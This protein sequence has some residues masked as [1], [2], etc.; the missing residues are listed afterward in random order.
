MYVNDGGCGLGNSLCLYNKF[1]FE[2]KILL[3]GHGCNTL[4]KRKRKRKGRF[5]KT[6]P[7]L[8]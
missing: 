4:F 7:P 3:R 1:N 2:D 6:H 8:M 5:F